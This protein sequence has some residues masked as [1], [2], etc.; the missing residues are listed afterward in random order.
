MRTSAVVFS[1]VVAASASA[2]TSAHAVRGIV[3]DSVANAPLAGAIVQVATRDATPGGTAERRLFSTRTDSTGHY[4]VTGLNAGQYVIG[5]QHEALNALGVE[6]P[7]RGFEISTE[8]VVSVDLATPS[9]AVL[10]A[11]RCGTGDP[12]RPGMLSG[13]VTDARTGALPGGG[14]VEVQW[15]ELGVRDHK[16][17]AVPFTERAD[18]GEDGSYVACNLA[19]DAVISVRVASLG[20]RTLN[21]E[22][23]VPVNGVLRRDFTLADT[24]AVSGRS[25]VTGKVLL[26][27]GKPLATGQAYI[28]ALAIS[29]PITNGQFTIP[30][31][32]A[33]TWLVDAR[34]LGYAPQSA[35][36]DVGEGAQASMT[37]RLD[38]RAQVLDAVTV[39]AK[40]GAKEI[41]IL[42][43]IKNR[44]R[45]GAGT[46]FLPGSEAL[47]H[48]VVPADVVRFARGFR[49]ISPTVV[50]GRNSSILSDSPGVTCSGKC[51]SFQP[52]S[53]VIG[54]T[55]NNAI[56][57]SDRGTSTK[58]RYVM[59][60]LDG[61][62]FDGGLDQLNAALSMHEVLAIE[63][64]PDVGNAPP[65]WRT[66]D[67]CAVIAVW[68]KTAA[69]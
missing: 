66:P 4:V 41:G 21:G 32:P 56:C 43:D 40:S 63:T 13:Y 42:M 54:S 46:V 47:R 11:V 20:H 65:E 51:T 57:S 44:A 45:M 8:S 5:F 3:F 10:R 26:S 59:L 55:F 28:A 62:R 29:E 64:Y 18:I 15:T 22:I 16:L 60:Y 17:K 58:S 50:F 27:D 39:V 48:A 31:I 2:Q 38:A 6:A 30:G 52:D 69:P 7:L 23:V 12:M 1:L 14:S 53:S 35:L 68:R 24:A 37:I 9:P 61:Q 33:G 49:Y 25:R 34:A 19:T 67:A 36:V